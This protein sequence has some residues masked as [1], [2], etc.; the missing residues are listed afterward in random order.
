MWD[1]KKKKYVSTQKEVD[2]KIKTESGNWIKSSF[3]TGK[4]DDY[5]HKQKVD[6]AE[7]DYNDDNDGNIFEKRQ[8]ASSNEK[9]RFVALKSS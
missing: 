4:Y 8:A 7:P 9:N 5:K 3:K 1:R 2:K 6:F